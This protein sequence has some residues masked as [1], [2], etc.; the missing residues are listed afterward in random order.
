MLKK[1]IFHTNI[2]TKTMQIYNLDIL[3]EY[4]FKENKLSEFWMVK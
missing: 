4:F 3:E 2:F 1:R